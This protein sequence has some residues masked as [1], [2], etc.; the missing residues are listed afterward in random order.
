MVAGR[1]A[2]RRLDQRLRQHEPPLVRGR[3]RP[4]SS[5]ERRS[6]CHRMVAGR[7]RGRLPD[8][9]LRDRRRHAG[10]NAALDGARRLRPAVRLVGAEPAR[11]RGREAD[12]RLRRAWSKAHRV[13]R[14][15]CRLV[16]RR[17]VP[18]DGP[19]PASAGSGPRRRS[20]DDRL[21]AAADDGRRRVRADPVAGRRAIA[22][23]QR[24]RLRRIRRR[25]QP[26]A[27]ASGA[28]RGV[29]VSRRRVGGRK[30]GLPSSPCTRT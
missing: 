2:P 28:V 17:L 18:G 30:R 9:R 6:R 27:P 26:A 14:Q 23:R 11:G 29:R 10:G 12:L 8:E 21:A 7:T 24:G 22:R 20:S 3:A 16:A 25:R 4:R 19:R 5:R 15:R 1:H 13:R